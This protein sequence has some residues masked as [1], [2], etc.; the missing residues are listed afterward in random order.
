MKRSSSCKKQGDFFL[1]VL[2]FGP[3]YSLS[4]A[5]ERWERNDYPGHLLYGVTKLNKYQITC[6]FPPKEKQNK[7]TKN[8]LI[9]GLFG[10]IAEQL[11]ALKHTSRYDVIYATNENE[12]RLILYLKRFGLFRKSI[13][14]MVHS[15][16]D[17]CK[18]SF[19]I[20]LWKLFYIHGLDGIG[21]LSPLAFSNLIKC[22]PSLRGRSE[23]ILMGP[24]IV[25]HNASKKEKNYVVSAGKTHRDFDTLCKAM[26]GLPCNLVLACP[27][28]QLP[29]SLPDNVQYIGEDI[30]FAT[31]NNLYAECL[32]IVIPVSMTSD[33]VTG[34]SSLADALGA[35]KPVIV[36]K[37][38]GIGYEI[39]DWGCGITYD[40]GD[41]S[42]L[43]DA[44]YTVCFDKY[45]RQ[46]MLDAIKRVTKE[47]NLD[48]MACQVSELI[49][50]YSNV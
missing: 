26:K 39:D 47:V 31:L 42:A 48:S 16:P 20:K 3:G 34:L 27:E 28:E 35:G 12:L 4:D 10:S 7:W 22:D 2:C 17:P 43:S 49:W 5:F 38:S 1:R 33:A 44:I 40:P 29:A 45:H 30:P 8:V 19:P 15:F 37:T 14:G 21:C 13:V 41:I 23:V 50:K 6:L 46:A 11:W 25:T 18:I 32:A 36:A 9:K 24:E